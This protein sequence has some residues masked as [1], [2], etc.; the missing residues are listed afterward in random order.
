MARFYLVFKE[1]FFAVNG[2]LHGLPW[3]TA[4]MGRCTFPRISCAKFVDKM[5]I[6]LIF[7]E[8]NRHYRHIHKLYGAV[9]AATSDEILS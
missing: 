1:I 2:R 8:T 5:T 6:G 3:H 7:N 4:S 9:V